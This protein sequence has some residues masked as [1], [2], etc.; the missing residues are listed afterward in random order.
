[1]TLSYS[2]LRRLARN[3]LLSKLLSMRFDKNFR[4]SHGHTSCLHIG[5]PD[6]NFDS[7][8][9]ELA[10]ILVVLTTT[11]A[12]VPAMPC[13]AVACS[14]RAFVKEGVVKSVQPPLRQAVLQSL[15]VLFWLGRIC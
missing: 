14:K 2:F 5:L 3:A 12:L 9:A 15:Q 7:S 10:A 11:S 8:F 1:M 4:H 6:S 13:S